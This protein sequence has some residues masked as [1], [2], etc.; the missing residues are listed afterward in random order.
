[1][2]LVR[3][4]TDKYWYTASKLRVWKLLTDKEWKDETFE[5]G[6]NNF[7]EVSR[8]VNIDLKIILLIAK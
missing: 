6:K 3:R 7:A 8:N 4:K 2:E 5:H 1:M